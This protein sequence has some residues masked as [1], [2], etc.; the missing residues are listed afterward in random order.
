MSARLGIEETLL[1]FDPEVYLAEA[2][3]FLV[4]VEGR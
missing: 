3:T 2:L 1:C 4:L